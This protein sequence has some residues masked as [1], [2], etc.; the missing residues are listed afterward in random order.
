MCEKM[1]EIY[2][3]HEKIIR[4][5]ARKYSKIDPAVGLEDLMSEGYLAVVDAVASFDPNTDL[6]FSSHLWWHLQK[7]F[8]AILSKDKVVEIKINGEKKTVSYNDFLRIK[9]SLPEDTEWKVTSILERLK[10][11]R[12][13]REYH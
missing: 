2:L 7:R 9:K 8:S 1:S 6:S 13:D 5:L 4:A 3:Q 12:E 10:E 11:D